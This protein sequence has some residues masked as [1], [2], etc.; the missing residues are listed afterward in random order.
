[1]SNFYNSIGLFLLSL[2]N[3]EDEL[4]ARQVLE[5]LLSAPEPLKPKTYNLLQG[6]KQ[7]ASIDDLIYAFIE[8]RDKT[9]NV[10]SV[11]LCL[12]HKDQSGYMIA[13]DKLHEPSFQLVSGKCEIDLLRE[14][15]SLL[16][17]LRSLA[18]KLIKIVKPIYGDFRSKAIKG[19][20]VVDLNV[21]LPDICHVS[22]FGPPYVE[23]F[24]KEVIEAAPYEYIEEI[25]PGYYWLQANESVFDPV[26]EAKKRAIREH[27][28]EDAFGRKLKGKPSRVPKFDFRNTLISSDIT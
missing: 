23:L 11:V 16:D 19:R 2:E 5:T 26:P 14:Q 12:D 7:I 22:I 6:D 3:F 15:P 27:F 18:Q 25:A 9:I 28:G 13:W 21:R 17:D 1:M 24:G 8:P 10:K 20:D 4:F